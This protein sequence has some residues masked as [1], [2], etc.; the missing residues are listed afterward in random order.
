MTWPSSSLTSDERALAGWSVTSLYICRSQSKNLDPTNFCISVNKQ[1]S[2]LIIK[3][4]EINTPKAISIEMVIVL[5]NNTQPESDT[6]L[7]CLPVS[8][9]PVSSIPFR[10]PV[11]LWVASCSSTLEEM[12]IT[13]FWGARSATSWNLLLIITNVWTLSQ[14]KPNSVPRSFSQLV[15]HWRKEKNATAT[16]T[17]KNMHFK[18]Y[19][20]LFSYGLH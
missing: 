15:L 17:S 20:E 14:H 1:T 6:L 13:N 2:N 9:N 19:F 18:Y 12:Q 16:A 8:P 3:K 4:F 5:H 7:R 11:V 10:L